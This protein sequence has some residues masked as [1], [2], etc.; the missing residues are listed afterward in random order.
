[1]IKLNGDIF[2]KNFLFIYEVDF[3]FFYS[4]KFRTILELFLKYI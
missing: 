3:Q 2:I 4:K 1:M